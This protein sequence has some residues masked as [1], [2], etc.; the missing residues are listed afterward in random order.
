MDSFG[1]IEDAYIDLIRQP[2]ERR[3]YLQGPICRLRM[4]IALIKGID[5]EEVQNHYEALAQQ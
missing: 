5:E 2:L 3:M 1:A 4:A